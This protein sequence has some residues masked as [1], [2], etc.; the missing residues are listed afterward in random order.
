MKKPKEHALQFHVDTPALL[1]EIADSAI[2]VNCGVLKIPLNVFKNLLAQ[3]A[4][5]AIRIND[6]R[7]NL[8]MVRLGLYEIKADKIPA[9]IT[10]LTNRIKKEAK[11]AK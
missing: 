1:K 9:I 11:A 10:K 4:Q 8:C 5:E 7:L 3:T 6:D 2:G